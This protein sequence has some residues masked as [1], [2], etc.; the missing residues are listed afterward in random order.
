[1][2]VVMAKKEPKLVEIKGPCF[3]KPKLNT[4]FGMKEFETGKQAAK[5]LLKVTGYKMSVLD[6]QMV[7]KIIAKEN[8]N[9]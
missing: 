3:A 4:N 7:G 1:M 8:A 2:G 9:A 5:Y 6:W